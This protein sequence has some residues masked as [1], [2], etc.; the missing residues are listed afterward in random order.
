MAAI[1]PL[2][3]RPMPLHLVIVQKCSVNG[4]HLFP[5]RGPCELRVCHFSGDIEV[6]LDIVLPSLA[7]LDALFSDPQRGIHIHGLVTVKNPTPVA[8]NSRWH[9]EARE[10]SKEH[11]QIV[12]LIL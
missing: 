6:R 2:F 10:R 9:A 8:D 3:V 5:A 11:L 7:W 1:L 4:E 12:P